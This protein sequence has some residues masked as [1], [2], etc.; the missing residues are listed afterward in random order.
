MCAE[1][2]ENLFAS[3]LTE[4]RHILFYFHVHG[5][6]MDTKGV[7]RVLFS[8]LSFVN[9]MVS[10]T[11]VCGHHELVLYTDHTWAGNFLSAMFRRK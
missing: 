5:Q 1:Q 9:A 11:I 7:L 2:H 6:D 3:M 8:G 10:Q 4:K